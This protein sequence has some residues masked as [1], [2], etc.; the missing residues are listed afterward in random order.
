MAFLAYE[1]SKNTTMPHMMPRTLSELTDGM[2]KDAVSIS[3]EIERLKGQNKTLSRDMYDEVRPR[4]DDYKERYGRSPNQLFKQVL[5]RLN[6]H[7]K[8]SPGGYSYWGHHVN[9]HE[10]AALSLKEKKVVE[11]P[12]LYILSNARHIR[13]GLDYGNKISSD[14]NEYVKLV[15]NDDAICGRILD[16]IRN[17]EGIGMY[18]LS[19]SNPGV[20]RREDRVNVGSVQDIKDNWRHDTHLIGV[21][22]KDRIDGESGRLIRE[23]LETLKPIFMGICGFGEVDERSP[24]A[25]PDEGV[26]AETKVEN[27][28]SQAICVTGESGVGKTYRV[29]RTLQQEGHEFLTVIIDSMWQHLLFDYSPIDREY[30][31]TKVGE[32][33]KDADKDRGRNYTLVIDECHK[34]LD[35]INDSLLQAI[36]LRRNEGVRFLSLNS[37]VDGQFGFLTSDRGR[38]LLPSNLGFVFISSKPDSIE[39]TKDL[40]NRIDIVK[41]TEEHKGNDDFSIDFLIGLTYKEA[42]GDYTD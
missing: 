17:N 20:L 24:D 23:G 28:L 35:I 21:I 6:Q 39:N 15:K 36:S 34:S 33:I 8:I 41:L 9:G 25:Y 40:S 31:L 12:Q 18:N 14:G 42:S 30:R 13:Y 7:E 32:F 16:V 22:E 5:S 11:S 27:R 29:E 4:I 3:E 19:S 2:L 38:R 10:W 26:G 1:T 37:L